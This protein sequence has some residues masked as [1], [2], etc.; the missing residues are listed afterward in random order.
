MHDAH[1]VESTI[2]A[3]YESISGPAGARDWKRL[4]S[5][6]FPGARLI[7]TSIGPG[8]APQAKVMEVEDYEADTAGYFRNHSFYESQVACRIDRFGNIAHAFST[9]ESRHNPEDVH[10]FVRGINSIQLFNDGSRWYVLS[11]LWDSER[12]GE[13]VPEMYMPRPGSEAAMNV[14]R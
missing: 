6:L 1:S 4:A 13:R 9:Y 14:N 7:R 5:L 8:G 10:S 2:K 3:L 11:V 12:E